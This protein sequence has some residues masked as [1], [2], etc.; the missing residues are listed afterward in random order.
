MNGRTRRWYA[1]WFYAAALYNVIWGSFVGLMPRWYGERL[2]L[3]DLPLLQAIGMMVAVFGFGYWLMAREPLRYFG[4]IW[5]A[6][7]GKTFGPA[8]FVIS[9]LKGDLPWSFGWINLTNDLIWL[10]VFIAFALRMKLPAAEY[11]KERLNSRK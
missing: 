3:T 2:G 7:L 9:A 8:G 5:I 11:D 4:F 6:I 10:P 1:G